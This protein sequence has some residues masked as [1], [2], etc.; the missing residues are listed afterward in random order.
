[1]ADLLIQIRPEEIGSRDAI[2][3]IDGDRSIEYQKYV[4]CTMANRS[5]DSLPFQV[6]SSPRVYLGLRFLPH[7]FVVEAERVPLR[8]VRRIELAI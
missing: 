6:S 5:G 7:V 3:S 2:F 1:M 4:A 8:E